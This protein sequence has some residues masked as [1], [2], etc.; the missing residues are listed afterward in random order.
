MKELRPRIA[1]Q[2]VCGLLMTAGLAAT[3]A[4]LAAEDL[5]VSPN[6]DWTYEKAEHLLDR[7]GFGGTPAQIEYLVKLGRDGAVDALVDFDKTP[8]NDPPY[9]SGT[10]LTPFAKGGMMLNLKQSDRLEVISVLQRIEYGNMEGVREWWLHRMVVTNHPFEEKMTLFWHGHF[11]SGFKEVKNWRSMYEENELERAHCVGKFEPFLMAIS[12]DSAM[13]EYLDGNSN[14]KGKPNENYARELMELFTM[15]VNT[16]TEQDIHESARSLTGWRVTKAGGPGV[17]VPRLHDDATKTFLG[18]T[19]NFELKDIVH[20]IMQQPSTSRFL[21]KE[22]WEYFAYKNPEP[23]VVEALAQ[24]LRDTDFDIKETMRLMFRCDQFYSDGAMHAQ[25][26]SPVELVVSSYRELGIPPNNCRGM[27]LSCAQMGEDLFQPP[28]VKGW[29]G[30][31]MWIN[32][33]TLFIRN[34]FGT[35]LMIGTDHGARRTMPNK[36]AGAED[37][38]TAMEEAGRPPS[39]YVERMVNA[40]LAGPQFADAR[41]TLLKMQAPTFYTAPEPAYDPLE[42]LK[43]YHLETADQVIAHYV[44]QL[45]LIDVAPDQMKI[46]QDTLNAGHPFAPDNPDAANKIRAAVSLMMTLPAFQLN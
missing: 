2:A 43:T 25:I 8:R 4:R 1:L 46:L 35:A 7:A 3:A 5:T 37:G 19:G 20:I 9:P 32:T 13:L 27:Y 41:Q 30:G 18:Q 21:A 33:S 28:N 6:P 12:T 11:T 26:K 17:F 14:L 23:W 36:K 29:D 24:K 42:T 16:Y 39:D 22:L 45:D 40:K 15:G 34:N 31:R 44:K 10:D 38:D